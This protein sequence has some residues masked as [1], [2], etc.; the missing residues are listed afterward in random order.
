MYFFIKIGKTVIL[1]INDIILI[2]S[3]RRSGMT[4]VL[5]GSLSFTCTPR[6]H[7]LTEWTMPAFA[8]P[9]EAGTHLTMENLQI[10][11]GVTFTLLHFTRLNVFFPKFQNRVCDMC[12]QIKRLMRRRNRWPDVNRKDWMRSVERPSSH[13][14]NSRLCT[15]DLKT[16]VRH[17]TFCTRYTE[18]WVS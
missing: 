8:F 9:A 7:P 4:R 6:V 15:V 11:A 13:A 3:L 10:Q 2:I 14:K 5:K 16:C 1:K 17:Y 12:V 18:F